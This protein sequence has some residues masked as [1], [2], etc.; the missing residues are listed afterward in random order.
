[1]N[2][3]L[4]IS[5]FSLM[6]IIFLFFLL[7]ADSV[8]SAA[9]LQFRGE[10]SSGRSED[11]GVP[12]EWSS[13]KN[14]QWRAPLP[15]PG[16]S[17]PI[18][19][20]GHVVVTCYS[21]YGVG[22]GD[23]GEIDQLVRHVICLDRTDG[24]VLWK[25]SIPARLPEDPYRG[26]ITEHGY[27]SSTPVS[28]GKNLFVFFGKTGVLAF[29]FDG[30]ELWRAEVGNE[31]S[32]RRWGSA[33]SPIL[34]GEH[35][36]VNASDESQSVL[37]LD[38]QTG[39]EVWRAEAAGLEL[40]YGTPLISER[41]DGGED[42]VMA[43]PD[44]VWGLDSLTGKL[45][46]YADTGLPGNICPTLSIWNDVAYGFGGYPT[47][48]S[49]AVRLGGKGDVTEANMLWKSRV[50]SYVATPVYHNEHL[51]WIT[52]RGDAICVR[53][54]DGVLVFNERLP[55]LVGDGRKRAV[56][57]SLVYANQLFYATTRFSG[58]YVFKAEPNFE[59]V[60]QNQFSEDQSQ[61]NGTPAIMGNQLY[62]R[63]DEYVYAVGNQR[64]RAQ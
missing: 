48:G 45:R 25:R 47:Q 41:S 37:A 44:E 16:S 49:F 15:G 11:L 21:G 6:G 18:V 8:Q 31:S 55:G 64:E 7:G 9:W 59:V 22:S 14:L 17:S 35:L 32:N 58:T 10:N 50:S 63:S 2:K 51:Y 53:A 39:K 28:D 43:V 4:N 13:E 5:V 24:K 26:Y 27:A 12:I 60:E 29:D 34:H 30:N 57:A 3:S 19:S 42:I 36:I 38:K 62:L 23:P 46:W 33:A 61:F 54:G 1:M 40:A 52:D 56:Y 20:G